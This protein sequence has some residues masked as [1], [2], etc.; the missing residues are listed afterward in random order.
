MTTQTSAPGQLFESPA[1]E[2]DVKAVVKAP[3][4]KTFRPYDQDQQFLLPPS[5][6]DWLPEGHLARF[7]DELVDEVLDLDPFLSAYTDVRGYSPYNPRLM[8]KLVLYGYLSGVRSSRK[9][10]KSCHDSVAFRFLAAN[11]APDFCSIARFRRRHLEALR[12]L[13]LESLKLC[14]AA[15]MVARA[16]RPGRHQA[17]GQRLE[18]QGHELPAHE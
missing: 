14:Q 8:I 15:G 4:D 17:P 12:G 18:A 3:V 11:A 13:F 10:E 1:Q 7:V 6:N 16:R 5:I 2:A 9:I